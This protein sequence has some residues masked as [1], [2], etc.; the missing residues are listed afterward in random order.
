[1]SSRCLVLFVILYFRMLVAEFAVIQNFC[2][3]QPSTTLPALKFLVEQSN[4]Y[5]GEMNVCED[6][7]FQRGNE[8]YNIHYIYICHTGMTQVGLQLEGRL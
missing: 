7:P 5:F 3:A 1:M 4:K 2:L 6:M 8:K